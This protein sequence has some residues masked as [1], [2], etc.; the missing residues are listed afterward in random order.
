MNW[1]EGVTREARAASGVPDSGVVTIRAAPV[2]SA[3][4]AAFRSQPHARVDQRVGQVDREV[5]QHE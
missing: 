3:T 1:R 5:Y 2:R 4:G